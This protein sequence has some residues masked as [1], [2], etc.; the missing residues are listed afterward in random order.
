LPNEDQYHTV[1]DGGN[2]V[3]HFQ[4]SFG[5]TPQN[6]NNASTVS[7]GGGSYPK[8]APSFGDFEDPTQQE[9]GFEDDYQENSDMGYLEELPDN[10]RVIQ[11]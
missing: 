9:Y 5:R 6:E 7:M 1:D 3:S 11:I 10:F 8:V 4:E 2:A